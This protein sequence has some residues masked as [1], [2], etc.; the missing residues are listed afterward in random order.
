M[1]IKKILIGTIASALMLGGVA[2]SAFAVAPTVPKVPTAP[3]QNKIVCEDGTHD[4]PGIYGG[5]CTL[6]SKGAK[7]TATL[8]NTVIVGDYDYAAVFINNTTLSGQ[9]LSKVTQLGYNY[10]GNISPLPGD[11]SLNVPI[12][13]NGDNKNDAYLFIDAYYCPGVAGNVDVINNSNCGIYFNG[14]DFYANWAAIVA[15][16]SA[17]K[18]GTLPADDLS[19][20]TLPFIIAERVNST[21]PP[22]LWTVGN[23]TL[24]KAGK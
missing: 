8:D 5:V 4:Y 6:P 20:G 15:A 2:T 9:V 13:T 21:E 7:G 17:W 10:S 1:N 12:D 19:V 18:V 14:V 23:I 3:G 24:G 16:H 11:L 22:A